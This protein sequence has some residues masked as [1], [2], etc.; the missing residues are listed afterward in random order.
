M[1]SVFIDPNLFQFHRVHASID[2]NQPSTRKPLA[3]QSVSLNSRGLSH[4]VSLDVP[5]GAKV[6]GT[7]GEALDAEKR[8]VY[9]GSGVAA[10]VK[11]FSLALI[12]KNNVTL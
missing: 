3:N 1:L 11:F 12:G 7:L 4:N 6:E 2:T 5:I 8:V 10:C 9:C